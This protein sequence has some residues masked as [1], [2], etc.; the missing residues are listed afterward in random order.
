[1]RNV[2]LLHLDQKLVQ[3]LKAVQSRR[4]KRTLVRH[5]QAG[6]KVRARSRTQNRVMNGVCCR[7]MWLSLEDLLR[8]KLTCDNMLG[9]VDTPHGVVLLEVTGKE[10]RQNSVRTSLWAGVH[11]PISQKRT[12]QVHVSASWQPPARHG[13]TEFWCARRP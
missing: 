6:T 12:A 5:G 8:E 13:A 4:T 7:A 2:D 1:M 11:K 3:P 9:S 10:R